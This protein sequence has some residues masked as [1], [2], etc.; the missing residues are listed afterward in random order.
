MP[1]PNEHACRVKNPGDFQKGS[2]R[3]MKRGKLS[4]I[5]GRLKGKTTTT[6]Q[7]FRYPIGTWTTAQ[8]RAHCK[9]QKGS[10]EAAQPK[11]EIGMSE[12]VDQPES[13]DSQLEDKAIVEEMASYGPRYGAGA[14]ATVGNATSFAELDSEQQAQQVADSV[15]YTAGQFQ[16]LVANIMASPDV[17]DK[18]SAIGKL[19]VE[20]SSKVG[21][22]MSETKETG[23][24]EQVSLAEVETAKGISLKDKLINAIKS[25]FE[26]D[27]PERKP[28]FTVWKEADGTYRWFAVFSN[29]YRDRDNPPEILSDAAHKEFVAAVD[30]GDWPMP[31]LWLWHV[32]G[33]ESGYADWL[34]YD[35][36]G[37]NCASG[38]VADKQVA[39]KLAGMG[40]LLV[41]HGMPMEHVKRDK[42]DPTIITGYR[43][44]EIS[45]LPSWAAA[46]ELTDFAL[47]KEANDMAIP[48]EKKDFLR[49]AGLSDEQIATIEDGLKEKAE[50]AK[51]QGLEF[52][53]T[54]AETEVTE[55][56][57]QV[58]EPVETGEVKPGPD[59]GGQLTRD[60]VVEAIAAAFQ[61][62]QQQLETLVLV[63]TEQAKALKQLTETDEAKVA[64][65]ASLTPAASLAE[66]VAQRVIGSPEAK[67]D[68]RKK[69]SKSGPKETEPTEP[70]LNP[71]PV[72][73]IN[74]LLTQG[75]TVN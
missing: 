58:T 13:E 15:H 38:V 24:N 54:E 59:D 39:G 48:E 55:A 18:A 73:F 62:L 42:D 30:A 23:E 1:F 21:E 47:L 6:T 43:S 2:F 32:K 46:N 60:E 36:N 57:E 68:G 65:K 10:F 28:G 3:R 26:T 33:S 71:T 41:S 35:D 75:Q 45:P 8:A 27:E 9:E 5:I 16:G 19:A 7:A 50:E 20:F 64:E 63:Q 56:E 29:K 51:E 4:I 31:K 25:V 12:Q 61:P 53:D 72:N 37:F 49:Q 74:Q 17:D 34:A 40:G 69:L 67:V 11:K 52:K 66:L 44:I 70:G 22:A 14:C